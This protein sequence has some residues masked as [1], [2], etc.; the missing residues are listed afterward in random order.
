MVTCCSYMCRYRSSSSFCVNVSSGLHLLITCPPVHVVKVTLG[1]QG[2]DSKMNF[3][4]TLN[5]LVDL[6]TCE[7]QRLILKDAM[8]KERGRRIW[9]G[10]PAG[11]RFC[12][13]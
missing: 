12:P 2:A 11:P 7:R 8:S 10:G 6:L 5:H 1:V 3:V 13:A 4:I 9:Y